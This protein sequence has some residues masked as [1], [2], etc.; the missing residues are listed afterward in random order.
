M[1]KQRSCFAAPQSG[2][3]KSFLAF[4]HSIVIMITLGM[5]FMKRNHWVR[6][7]CLAICLFL[8]GSFCL[9]GVALAEE[10]ILI[11]QHSVQNE[12][13][14]TVSGLRISGVDAP[15]AGQKLDDAAVV[16]STEGVS[17][18]IP[19]LWL[20]ETGKLAAE[21][22]EGAQYL[23]ALAFFVPADYS[24]QSENGESFTVTLE[25]AVQA[26][27]GTEGILAIYDGESGVTYI[28]AKSLTGFLPDAAKAKSERIPGLPEELQQHEGDYYAPDYDPEE[29]MGP[30]EDVPSAPATDPTELVNIHC[31]QT[32]QNAMSLDE[33]SKIVD[34]VINH[35][36][37][38][39]VNLLLSKFPAFQAAAQDRGF[40]KGMGL[41]M[42]YLKGDDDGIEVHTSAPPEALAYVHK[43][44]WRADDD[45]LKYGL[46]MGM[47]L[48]SFSVTDEE[49]NIVLSSSAKT[50]ADFD[51]TVVHEMLHGFMD[52]YNRVGMTGAADPEILFQDAYESRLRVFQTMF[53]IWFREGIASAMENVYQFRYD[54]FQLLS[55]AGPGIIES[56]YT[57]RNL[58]HAYLTNVFETE[59]EEYYTIYYDLQD[60]YRSDVP[61]SSARYVT[62][63]LATLYL[64]DLAAQ[65]LG[66]PQAVQVD[67]DNCI[68]GVSSESIRFGVNSI[69]EQLNSGKTLDEIIAEISDGRYSNTE[70]FEKKFIKGTY[71]P[72]PD[73]PG[74]VIYQGDEPSQFFCA[75]FL[76]YMR[77]LRKQ[78]G[79]NYTPN[80]S[81]LFDFA[82]DYMTP[83]DRDQEASAE[84]Y[85]IVDSNE[86][87]ESSVDQQKALQ[88]G[89]TSWSG[90][91]AQS[92]D[93]QAAAKEG[94]EA[95]PA[96]AKT[97]AL[98]EEAPLAEEVE[99]VDDCVEVDET[100]AVEADDEIIA[101]A[102]A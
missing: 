10:P 34:L 94:A 45:S 22:V 84:F 100:E 43:G 54:N 79:R 21:A 7:L 86:L 23:P 42:Y 91:G 50:L 28:T 5:L 48:S 67:Q 40:S 51:N 3:V 24:V 6:S 16:M 57:P 49:G 56:T 92:V 90:T 19:V 30:E 77:D 102:A 93:E 60:S 9:P 32:A 99:T 35:V 38:Q 70:D 37:P 63:Y 13:A 72:D 26:L 74:Y 11:E 47:D 62:G 65:K 14:K 66:N 78:E 101:E 98:I 41:Y 95:M 75:D 71:V 1:A 89:G 88:N 2:T 27:F 97:A 52:D 81:I 80:G 58:L 12:A 61:N 15:Q 85:R 64:G 82:D 55:Y 31:S 33:L 17:W 59:E 4:L 96:A 69:L 20:D 46:M 73:I 8:L 87:V 36:Q 53:P 68:V 76:N 39:A 25:D 18:F 83:L 29:D 44:Y